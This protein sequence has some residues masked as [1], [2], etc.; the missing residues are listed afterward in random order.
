MK[1]RLARG[2]LRASVSGKK[3]CGATVGK[4]GKEEE[5]EGGIDQEGEPSL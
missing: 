2:K 5:K 1:A 4:R 3:R